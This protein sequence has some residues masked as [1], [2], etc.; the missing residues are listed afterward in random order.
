VPTPA[1]ALQGAD[2]LPMCFVALPWLDVFLHIM[3]YN[4][5]LLLLQHFKCDSNV[6]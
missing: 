4:L 6:M 2:L 3:L 5:C 1:A